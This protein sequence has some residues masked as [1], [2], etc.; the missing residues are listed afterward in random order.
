MPISSFYGMQTSLRGLMA[1]QR[2]LDTT[3]HNIANA[4]TVGYSRQEATLSASQALQLQV[5]GSA[6]PRPAPT[7]APA[8][9]SQA[10][11]ASA[12]SSWTSQFRGQNT[13]LNEWKAQTE[14]LDTRRAVARR[15]RR[16]R[17]QRPA[18]R[19]SGTPGLTSPSRPSDEAAKQ[20][21]VQKAGA[22]TDSIHVACAR[23]WSPRRR[24]RRASTTRSPARA[25]TS[26]QIATEL[27]SLNKTICSFLTQRR[28]AERPDGPPRPAARPALRLGQ[29][30]VE[31]LDGGSL[32]V[33]FVDGTSGTTYPIVADQTATGPARRPPA[34]PGRPDGRPAGRRQVAGRHDRRLPGRRSTRSRDARRHGQRAPTAA[35]FFTYGAPA[36]RHDPGRRRAPGRAGTRHVRHGRGRLQRHRARVSQL[37]GNAAIDGAYKA[38]VA[39]VGGDLNE[40]TR[41]QAN[42]Q[43]LADSV[44][45]RRQSV[46]GRL[47]GRGDVQPRA[48][49]ARLPGVGASDVDDGRDARRAHQPHRPGGS[50]V[51][52][53]TTSMVQRNVLSDLNGL[54]EKLA[55]TQGKASSGKEITRPSDDPF[56]A[57]QAMGLR[58][59][60]ERQRPVP[61]QHR[62]RAGLAGRDRGRARLDHRL[63]QPRPRPARAG[64]DRHGRP[65]R[66]QRDRLR[67]RPDH[68]GHQ[69]DRERHLRRQLPDVRHATTARARTSSAPTTPTRATR[70]ASTRPSRASCARSAP[71]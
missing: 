31:Q 44:E 36:G 54:S 20:A 18:R 52:R 49:P 64:R 68:R 6:N 25:A 65:D 45:N 32:N 5:S 23:R 71:A 3:G 47:D 15:A 39:K 41:M 40:A 24:P 55:R 60:L 59:T 63:R 48:L 42:A 4:S 28:L 58:Q 2:M 38:F 69:G 12:T 9:T 16:Q 27:A 17:H 10:S 53:I 35:P 1:Q 46:A 30:S 7:S 57:A 50:L 70:P 43:V 56:N 19:S 29:I 66:A 61:A 33:S 62:G 8:S 13:S 26:T 11:A 51:M 22:L 14:A 21:L 37:R 67:D 34:G